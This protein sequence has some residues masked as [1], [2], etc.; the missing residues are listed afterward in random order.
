MQEY[1]TKVGTKCTTLLLFHDRITV[2]P[3]LSDTDKKQ[4]LQLNIVDVPRVPLVTEELTYQGRR[5]FC[6]CRVTPS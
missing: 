5:M 3:N 2:F 1:L 6:G 4:S